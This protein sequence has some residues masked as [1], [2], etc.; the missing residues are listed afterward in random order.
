LPPLAAVRRAASLISWD[1]TLFTFF[2][3]QEENACLLV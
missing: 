1:I 2:E 3:Y